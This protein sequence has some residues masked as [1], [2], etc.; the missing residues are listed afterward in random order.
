MRLVFGRLLIGFVVIIVFFIAVMILM[1]WLPDRS[2]SRRLTRADIEAQL[3]LLDPASPRARALKAL[4]LE[5]A[6]ESTPLP[7]TINHT[8]TDFSLAVPPRYQARHYEKTD[9]I[10]TTRYVADIGSVV[11]LVV[12]VEPFTAADIE[13]HASVKLRRTKPEQYEERYRDIGGSAGMEFLNREAEGYEKIL[14]VRHGDSL[15]TIAMSS[16]TAIA[17]EQAAAD[18]ETVLASF[19]WR[20]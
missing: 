7:P 20:Y 17:R 5:M 11:R 8:T 16:L 12:S 4:L 13:E 19:V 15:V 14:F 1:L 18:Y 10:E 3:Q 6:G 9:R 2:V